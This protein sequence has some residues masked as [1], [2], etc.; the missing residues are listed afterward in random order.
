MN[1]TTH[2]HS[3]WAGIKAEVGIGDPLANLRARRAMQ[4]GERFVEERQRRRWRQAD[5]ARRAGLAADLID[6][7][8]LGDPDLPI[9]ILDRISQTLGLTLVFE[10]RASSTEV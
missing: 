10:L 8:E 5:V 6:R 3:R 1:D 9:D 2:R 4:I 7:A